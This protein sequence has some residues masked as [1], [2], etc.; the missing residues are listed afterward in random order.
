VQVI[1]EKQRVTSAEQN[2]VTVEKLRYMERLDHGHLHSKNAVLK[3][4]VFKIHCF[5]FKKCKNK[6]IHQL[7]IH[8]PVIIKFP[9]IR[10]RRKYHH[11]ESGYFSFYF[12]NQMLPHTGPS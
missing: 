9:T 2:F 3:K 5:S 12:P 6:P 11:Y 8:I 7:Q 4:K 1:S 10:T